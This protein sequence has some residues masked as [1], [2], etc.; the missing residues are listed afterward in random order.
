MDML[1]SFDFSVVNAIQENMKCG[2]FDTVMPL[3]S[4]LCSVIW[5]LFGLIFLF[6]KKHRLCGIKIIA[7]L[8][9]AALITEFIVKPVFMRERP[10]MLNPE[11]VMLVSEPFGSS[12]PSGHTSTSFASAV[13]FF[14]INKKS[15]IAALLF[16]VIVAFSRLYLYVHFL[17]DVLAGVI[18][19]TIIGVLISFVTGKIWLKFSERSKKI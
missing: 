5:A 15:G 2:F 12:F 11:H 19:G 4:D 17:T 6:I 1:Q 8:A 14:G 13:Q 18:L 9:F 7:A 16:A 10:Y 3:V